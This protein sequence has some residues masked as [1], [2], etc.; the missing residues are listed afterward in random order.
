MV[1]SLSV[2]VSLLVGTMLGLLA[3]W[4]GG[5]AAILVMRFVDTMLSIP[6]I[7]LA[8]LAQAVFGHV[9]DL[10]ARLGV[11]DLGDVDLAGAD[12]RLLIGSA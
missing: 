8:V 3:G 5:W 11:L 12:P 9:H 6:A 1:A 10:G 4:F 7:L 2:S